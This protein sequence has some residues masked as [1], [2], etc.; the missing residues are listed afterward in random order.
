MKRRAVFIDR[1]GTL[2]R[3]VGYPGDFSQIDIYSYS[4]EAVR[5]LRSAGFAVVIVTNQS[6]V[7]RGFFTEEALQNIHGKLAA[8][9]R[10]QNAPLDGL[11]YCPHYLT[12]LNPLYNADCPCR[13]P[14]PGMALRAA[15]ELG[16]DLRGSY[17]IGDKV[18]DILFG[19][20]IQARP[21]LVLTGYGTESLKELSR[22]PVQPDYV[23]RDL[24]QAAD[25]I[26]GQERPE[27]PL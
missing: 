24:L 20:N 7:G 9:F 1:D 15:A 26:L 17:M 27:A 14:K 3:D 23:A 6:G 22:R 19:L 5:K 13:K 10:S 16:L 12:S 4:Y 21:I 2:N 18:E 25:W 8:A 11:Y